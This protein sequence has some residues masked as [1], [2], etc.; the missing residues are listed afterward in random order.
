MQPEYV[1]YSNGHNTINY[2][3]KR[4]SSQKASRRLSMRP[5]AESPLARIEQGGGRPF[6]V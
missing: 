1:T 2:E 4:T 5:N 3:N 6:C